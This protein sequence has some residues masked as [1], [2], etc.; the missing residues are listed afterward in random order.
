MQLERSRIRLGIPFTFKHAA[1][2]S[3][4][5]PAPIITGSFTRMH[6]SCFD[7]RKLWYNGSC[8]RFPSD[9]VQTAIRYGYTEEK[10]RMERDYI[11][12]RKG[13]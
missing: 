11:R 9:S 12:E 2:A 4:E 5:G 10:Y 1:T 8:T 6:L 13:N 3:P 7:K